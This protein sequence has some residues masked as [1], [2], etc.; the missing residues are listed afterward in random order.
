MATIDIHCH[1]GLKSWLFNSNFETDHPTLSRDFFPTDMVVDYPKL[2][3]GEVD[4]IL[5]SIYLPESSLIKEIDPSKFVLDV[6]NLFLN[7]DKKVEENSSPNRPFEQT[8]EFINHFEKSVTLAKEKHCNIE[9]AH[10]YL[11]LENLLKEGKKV[12]LH[13]IEGAHSLGRKI[14][15]KIPSYIDNIDTLFNKGVCL[16]TL[17]HFYENDIVAPVIGMPPSVI[18][19]LKLSGERDPN[20]GLT[21]VG[22]EVVKHMLDIGMIADLTHCTKTARDRIFEI[23]NNRE[24]HKRPLVFS[25]VGVSEMFNDL[26]NPAKDEINKIKDCGGVIGII[27][28][29]YF[30]MG[31]EEIDPLSPF[32][33]LKPEPGIEYILKTIDKIYSITKTYDNISIGTD[34]DGFTDPPDDLFNIAQFKYLKSRLIE[35]YGPDIALKILGDNMLRVLKSGWGKNN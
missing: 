23:N 4:A 5:S 25:H 16:L 15:G 19:K 13:S 14:N 7:A 2:V 6:L 18:R 27:F 29:R 26:M 24:E 28:Y 35:K 21:T 17:A 22:E 33:D 32:I 1:P 30:L 12:I 3:Q 34:L 20:K 11:E 8:I 31:K 9:I 10:N